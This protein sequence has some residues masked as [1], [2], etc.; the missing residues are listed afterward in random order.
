LSSALSEVERFVARRLF[1]L[2]HAL[3][4]RL[5]ARLAV[6]VDGRALEPEIQLLLRLRTLRGRADGL[7][8]DTPAKARLAY[9]RETMQFR[10]DSVPV[11]RTERVVSTPDGPLLARHYVPEGLTDSGPL[12]VYFHGGGFVS[13]D[14]DTH[15]DPCAL[16]SHHGRLRI[17]S[18]AYRLA[19]EH[20]FPAAI[21]D[22]L[23]AYRWAVRHAIDLG[24]DPERIGVG[25][26]S[27]GGNLAAVVA[28]LTSRQGKGPAF[29]VLIYPTLDSAGQW[30]SQGHFARGYVL[31]ADDMAWAR[32]HYY[33]GAPEIAEDVRISPL[34]QAELTGLAPA[35]VVTAG[36]D[37]LRDEGDAY[38]KALRARGNPVVHVELGGFVHGFLHMAGVSPAA[39]S[40][41]QR[42]ALE[43]Q[44]IASEGR[45]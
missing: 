36:F 22:A 45:L 44:G 31:T 3:Q 24:A 23:A 6:V 26:D 18:V 5:S 16:M 9:R 27:A 33:G 40:A 43:M 2:P 34:R 11:R 14:L 35:L 19:P 30:P 17:L 13:G 37:P 12:V 21:D 38:A 28:Q 39:M 32:H 7:R 41:V 15:D 20:P 25:G 29:Q 1:R 42:V 8:A 4:V 10:A